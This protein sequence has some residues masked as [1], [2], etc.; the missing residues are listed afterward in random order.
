MDAM[1][2][3][4]CACLFWAAASLGSFVRSISKAAINFVLSSLHITL[5]QE[6]DDAFPL[7]Q[8]LDPINQGG[9]RRRRRSQGSINAAAGIVVAGRP[10]VTPQRLFRRGFQPLGKGGDV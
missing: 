6:D 5:N 4:A 7:L 10:T 8:C 3:R 1:A 2:A 9:P